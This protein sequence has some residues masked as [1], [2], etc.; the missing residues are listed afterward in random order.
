MPLH[1]F[2]GAAPNGDDKGE[3]LQS[4]ATHRTGHCHGSRAARPHPTT[5]NPTDPS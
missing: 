2:A 5:A 3:A 1:R 4:W